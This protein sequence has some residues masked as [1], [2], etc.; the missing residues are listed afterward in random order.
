MA[1][2]VDPAGRESALLHG[3][4]SFHGAAVI[5]IGCGTGRTIWAVAT[6]AASVLGVDP[7][8]AAIAEAQTTAAAAGLTNVNLQAADVSTL[9]LPPA[10]LDIALFSRSL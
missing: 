3:L 7:D 4:L 1:R 6:L 5:D 2:K 8:E 10:S 9:D